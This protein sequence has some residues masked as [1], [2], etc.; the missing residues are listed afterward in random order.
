ML[1]ENN[2]TLPCHV[3]CQIKS[4][5]Q[6]NKTANQGEKGGSKEREREREREREERER[7]RELDRGK[8]VGG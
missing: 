8:G 4:Y 5:G 1:Y 2:G 3:T 7:E 6:T